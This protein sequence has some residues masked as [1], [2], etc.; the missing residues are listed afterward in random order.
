MEESFD[1]REL[2]TDYGKMY[3]LLLD[4][5][6]AK[7]GIRFVASHD[8]PKFASIEYHPVFFDE[9]KNFRIATDFIIVYPKIYVRQSIPVVKNHLPLERCRL[10]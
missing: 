2:E 10:Q 8:H 4:L 9:N 7:G 1:Y 6:G 5:H 3:H